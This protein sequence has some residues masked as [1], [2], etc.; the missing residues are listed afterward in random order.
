M[1]RVKAHEIEL[2]WDEFGRGDPA[3]LVVPQWFLSSKSMRASALVRKLA[4]HHRML[5]YDRRGTGTSDKPG[6]PYTTA[7]DS[8]DLGAMVDA[9][10]MGGVAGLGVGMP[11]GPG[12]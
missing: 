10:G 7:R 8:R 1:N 2:A 4:D 3:I 6:P 9:V 12:E 5:L 11:G